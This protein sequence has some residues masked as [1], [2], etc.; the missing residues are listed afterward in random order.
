[1][2][3]QCVPGVSSPPSQT[4]GYEATLFIVSCN[5]AMLVGSPVMVC[6]YIAIDLMV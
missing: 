4:P 5:D 3:K 6:L 2:R 1:M